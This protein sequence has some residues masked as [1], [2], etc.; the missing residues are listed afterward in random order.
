MCVF[1][2]KSDR[3]TWRCVSELVVFILLKSCSFH[4]DQ[5]LGRRCHFKAYASNVAVA[6]LCS[7]RL[8]KKASGLFLPAFG[9]R[10]SCLQRES[11]SGLTRLVRE[12]SDLRF[13]LM[14]L[15]L[16]CR[17]AH[18]HNTHSAHTLS[19]LPHTCVCTLSCLYHSGTCMQLYCWCTD[20]HTHT[21]TFWHERM[22][23]V[24]RLGFFFFF[25]LQFVL[26]S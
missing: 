20:T 13:F 11:A 3:R 24:S 6:I 26:G 9:S 4:A 25:W 16:T 10:C 22:R 5:D 1:I 18:V 14:S 8:Q 17:N 15:F 21:Y 23:L 2:F 7:G 19:L 12:P